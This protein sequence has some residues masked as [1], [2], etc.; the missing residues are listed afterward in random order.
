MCESPFRLGQQCLWQLVRGGEIS[1]GEKRLAILA[2]KYHTVD[3]ETVGMVR[4]A[5]IRR[6]NPNTPDDLVRDRAHEIR[7]AVFVSPIL[8]RGN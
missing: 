6:A 8:F 1:R 3:V 4:G 5:C 2:N 7:E